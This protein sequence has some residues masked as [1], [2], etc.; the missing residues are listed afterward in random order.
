MAQLPISIGSAANDGTGTNWRTAFS[1]IQDNFTDLYAVQ[2]RTMNAGDVRFA[3]EAT[4]EA[5]IEAAALQAEVELKTILFIPA[6]MIPYDGTLVGEHPTLRRVREGGNW[7]TYDARAYGVDGWDVGT[8]RAPPEQIVIDQSNIA[9]GL[10]MIGHRGTRTIAPENT[11]A[12]FG[13]ASGF[14]HSCEFDVQ[15]SS[16]GIPVVIHDSTVD[17]TSDL[18]GNVKDLSIAALEAGDFGSWF[19]ARFT[20]CKIPRFDAALKAVSHWARLIYVEIKGYRTQADV[21]LFT[22]EIVDLGLEDRVVVQ[23]FEPTDYPLVRAVSTRVML[24]Y[25]CANLTQVN[26]NLPLAAADGSAVLIV[27]YTVLLANPTVVTDA[28]SYGI[29]LVAYGANTTERVR[30]L[31]DIGVRRVMSDTHMCGMLAI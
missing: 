11:L 7:N 3:G 1:R 17:R 16:D 10:E 24:G 2:S 19:G 28:R 8:G 29:D 14:C 30:A 31:V 20:G 12:A 27:E 6:E 15:F 25:T 18:T 26:T 21:S 5:R 4:T 22:Q 23:S 9:G 13:A